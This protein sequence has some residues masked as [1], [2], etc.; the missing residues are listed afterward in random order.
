M[1]TM[2]NCLQDGYAPEKF[3]MYNMYDRFFAFGCSFTLYKWPTWADYLHAGNIATQYQ[4]W[5]LP[6]GSNNFIFHSLTECDALNKI[7][8]NDLVVIMWSQPHRI[9]DYSHESGWDMPGN[10]YL[11]QPRDRMIQYYNNEQNALENLSYFYGAK[12]LLENKDCAWLFTSIERINLQEKY[13]KNFANITNSFHSSIAEHLGYSD[14]DSQETDWRETLPNDRHPS[15]REQASFAKTL[16]YNLNVSEID[17][18]AEK[19]NDHIFNSKR[20]HKQEMNVFPEK[21]PTHRLPD[22]EGKL[23]SGSGKLINVNRV[24]S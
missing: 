6:G 13:V 22:I 15:P 10:A 18:L 8:K 20:P 5:A 3:W 7:N 23:N 16:P 9:A 14:K 2:L 1:H 11:Y 4:N 19:A 24:Q 12:E 17:Q 21:Y